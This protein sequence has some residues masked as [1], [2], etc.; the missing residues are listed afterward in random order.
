MTLTKTSP[1]TSE[2]VQ[3]GRQHGVDERTIAT[4]HREAEAAHKDAWHEVVDRK[5]L[6]WGLD[7]AALEDDGLKAPSGETI[8]LACKVAAAYRDAG[9]PP[10]LRVVPTASAGIAFERKQGSVFETVTVSADG[11]VEY[12]KYVDSRLTVRNNLRME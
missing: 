8:A 10:P 1:S 11:K 4:L 6:E 9:L 5:L 2:R 3:E 12:A 7:P